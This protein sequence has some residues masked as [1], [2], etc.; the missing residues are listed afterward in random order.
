VR[1]RRRAAAARI[2]Y[3]TAFVLDVGQSLLSAAGGTPPPSGGLTKSAG[4]HSPM[5]SHPVELA[6][7]LAGLAEPLS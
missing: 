4:S 6:A 2:V 3:L 5:L 1:Q 7:L